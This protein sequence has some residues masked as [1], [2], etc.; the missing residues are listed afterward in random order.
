MWYAGV[1]LGWKSSVITL[2]SDDGLKV[3]PKRFLNQ[4]PS[5][6][7]HFLSRH[8]PFKAVIKATG[9]LCPS[10]SRQAQSLLFLS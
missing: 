6:I 9:K 1:D 4:N 3:L 5:A 8:K 2:I 7:A 10:L